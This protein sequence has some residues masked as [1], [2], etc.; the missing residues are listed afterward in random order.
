MEWRILIHRYL[1]I[2]WFYIVKNKRVV[3]A[4]YTQMGPK[5]LAMLRC[6]LLCA[7]EKYVCPRA[8][9]S[10]GSQARKSVESQ[11]PALIRVQ[12][13]PHVEEEAELSSASSSGQA[14]GAIA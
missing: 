11:S 4:K 13:G 2:L 14:R 6:R 10:R 8:N 3:H 12:L 1:S 7:V 9:V 5:F